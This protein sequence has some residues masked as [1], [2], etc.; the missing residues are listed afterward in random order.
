MVTPTWAVWITLVSGPDVNIAADVLGATGVRLRYGMSGNGP[1]DCLASTGEC[2]F[3]LR[4]DARNS[5]ATQGKY[6]PAHASVLAGFNYGIGVRIVFTYGGTDYTKF[7]GKVH[8][9]RPMPGLGR[10]ERVE[11]VAYDGMGDLMQADAREVTIQTSKTEAQ[12]LTALLDALPTSA[13]PTARSIDTGV[14]TYPYAF[15][16]VGAGT[17]AAGVAQDIVQ[18][19]Y[20]WAFYAG[21]GTFT[22]LSRHTRAAVSSSATFTNSMHGLGVPSSLDQTYNRVRATI[23]PKTIDA[24]ATTVIASQTGSAPDIAA[25]ASQTIWLTFRDPDEVKRLIGG[26]SA[27]TPIVATTDY[28]AND[29]ADGGG[30]DR[31][32]SVSVATTVFASSAKFVVTNNYTGTV[33]LTK[34]QLRGKGVYDDGPRTFEA[35]SVQPYGD[36]PYEFDMPYQDDAEIGQSAATFIEASYNDLTQQVNSLEFVANQSDALMLQALTREPGDVVTITE[37]MTGLSS[38]RAVI[39]SVEFEIRAG[40]FIIC[41]WGLAPASPFGI[42]QIGVTGASELGVTTTLGF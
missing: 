15:D 17:K 36:R 30:T 31:T 29:A 14:D 42:W 12:L 25:G 21:D 27:V 16:N 24:A 32:A 2:S 6:S 9:I 11:L 41:R 10:G 8:V 13:Q 19:A 35:Y 23:H 26:L 28:T 20:G 7:V 33:Y 22:Y 1:A 38:V 18:S 40:L 37:T 34:L 3:T 39:T 5:Y 4:N